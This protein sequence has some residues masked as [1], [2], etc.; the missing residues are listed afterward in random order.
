MNVP[1]FLIGYMGSGKTT[2]GKKLANKMNV[3]FIDLD[4]EIVKHIGMPIAQ[5]FETHSEEAFRNLEREFLQKQE[6][7]NGIISTGGGTPCFHDNMNWINERGISLYLK[8]TP[9]SL[10]D[11]LSKSDVKKRPILLGLKGEELY[12]F[13][14]SKLQEREPFYNQAHIIFEKLDRNLDEIIQLIHTHNKE[15][16]PAI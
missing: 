9:K 6:G 14:E 10:W 16:S 3:P 7:V 8:M 15:N 13:I 1:V 11:R 5:Y 12:Q 2:I 4:E